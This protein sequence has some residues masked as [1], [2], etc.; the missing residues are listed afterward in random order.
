MKYLL[1][2]DIS[3]YA[4]QCLSFANKKLCFLLFLLLLLQFHV[5]KKK[6]LGVGVVWNLQPYYSQS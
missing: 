6:K 4:I 2:N 5:I 1:M 3:N